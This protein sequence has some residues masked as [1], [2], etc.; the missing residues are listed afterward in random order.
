MATI[1]GLDENT[2]N[3]L[4]VFY[5]SKTI[6]NKMTIST[7][8]NF[9]NKDVLTNSS[10]A[11]HVNKATQEQ[12]KLLKPFLDKNVLKKKVLRVYLLNFL[13]WMKVKLNNYFY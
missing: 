9:L 13:E 5:S 12:I 6:N 7:F 8:I 1:L 2:V 10:Y 11:S 3:D 4:F